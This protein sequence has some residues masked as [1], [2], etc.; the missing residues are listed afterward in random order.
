MHSALPVGHR[1]LWQ[2]EQENRLTRTEFCFPGGAYVA[3]LVG[4]NI[5][6]VGT[7]S[8]AAICSGPVSPA[9]TTEACSMMPANSSKPVRPMAFTTGTP[10]LA[11][12]S[13]PKSASARPPHK[14]ILKSLARS[15]AVAAKNSGGQFFGRP[16]R[17]WY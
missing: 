6:T 16:S 12:V 8:A 4:P 3:G 5:A 11:W 14:T 2:K 1:Y 10:A 9:T 7:P 15:F 13:R 17:S